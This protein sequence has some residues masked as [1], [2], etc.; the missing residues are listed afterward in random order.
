[1]NY[2]I[3]IIVANLYSHTELKNILEQIKIK[4][5][6]WS[7]R[8]KKFLYSYID[9]YNS[10][11]VS[12][13]ISVI[14]LINLF[15]DG[16]LMY[17]LR[18]KGI[19]RYSSG[20]PYTENCI[21]KIIELKDI[22]NIEDT[23]Y[24]F[25]C[26][27]KS[28]SWLKDYYSFTKNNIEQKIKLRINKSKK[29]KYG[30]LK[31]ETSLIL[32]LMIFMEKIY[33]FDLEKINDNYDS[34]LKNKLV[35]YTVESLASAVSYLLYL[36][37][38]LSNSNI[39]YL[40]MNTSLLTYKG[41]L[42]E[43]IIE[44]A[45]FKEIEEL[46]VL[47]DLFCYSF[48][49]TSENCLILEDK[50][51]FDKC[52]RCGYVKNELQKGTNFLLGINTGVLEEGKTIDSIIENYYK[53]NKE[54][55]FEKVDIGTKME[56]YKF[57]LNSKILEILKLKYDKNNNP[58]LFKYEINEVLFNSRELFM[59]PE[60]FLSKKIT[61]D[62]M[63]IDILVMKRFF[64]FRSFLL[65]KLF[66]Y[67]VKSKNIIYR[68]MIPVMKR[69]QLIDILSQILGSLNKAEQLLNLFTYKGEGILDIQLTPIIKIKDKY[70]IMT[71]VL[72]NSNLI[73]N[74]ISRSR[75]LRLQL[76]NSDGLDD[77][78]ENEV[79]NLFSNSHLNYTY[80]KSIKYKYDKKESEIDFLICSEKFLFII[81]CK[82]NLTPTNS[83]DLRTTVDYI[84]TACV[85]LKLSEKAFGDPIFRKSFFKSHNIIEKDQEVI[86]FILLGNRIF[87][88]DNLFEYP[89]CYIHEL[90]NFINKGYVNSTFYKIELWKDKTF[91]E[92]DLIEYIKNNTLGH[93]IYYGIVPTDW[94]YNYNNFQ[95]I[96]KTYKFDFEKF[97]IMMQNRKKNSN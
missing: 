51:K 97:Y 36:T 38:T 95:L 89:I 6:S 93:L 46:E 24:S 74:S 55:I 61:Q 37:I 5:K 40:W 2:Y 56:R 27:K 86:S 39:S 32:E 76:T 42:D 79:Q 18:K 59:I 43:L 15:D 48:N 26:G 34:K 72:C 84:K 49:K 47:A 63:L 28:A 58:I 3:N 67:E 70:Y 35:G 23:E 8:E 66:K 30:K 78:L 9:S 75:K 29:I 1:M 54:K 14:L 45:K 22:L 12:E 19:F 13:I 44:A 60:N 16:N 87:S 81:E 94:I 65:K 88:S 90:D 64:Y 82:N 62:C 96:Y 80:L 25:L 52:L 33:Y 17:Y 21:D 41:K 85:Q 53:E 77:P 68:S 10:K 4:K 83:Y 92:Y 71:E 11:N 69:E 73:I 91:N 57:K 31:L 50:D 7:N 20:W